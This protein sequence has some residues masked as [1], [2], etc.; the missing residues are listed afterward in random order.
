[1]CTYLKQEVVAPGTVRLAPY[2]CH[3]LLQVETLRARLS[4]SAP[5]HHPQQELE[6]GPRALRG[7]GNLTQMPQIQMTS[8]LQIKNARTASVWRKVT[9]TMSDWMS[10]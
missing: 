7:I 10:M 9:S 5:P 8:V 3:P 2:L 6:K 1:M 4:S